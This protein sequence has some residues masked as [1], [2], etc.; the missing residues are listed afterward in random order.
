MQTRRPDRRA[1]CERKSNWWPNS[2]TTCTAIKHRVF[3][4]QMNRTGWN[5]AWG[6]CQFQVIYLASVFFCVSYYLCNL[7]AKSS[8]TFI[9]TY[10]A[11]SPVL[12][13]SPPQPPHFCTFSHSV[14]KGVKLNLRIRRDLCISIQT[15]L[16]KHYRMF[17]SAGYNI[18]NLWIPVVSWCVY[19]DR[20]QHENKCNCPHVYLISVASPGFI[21]ITNNLSFLSCYQLFAT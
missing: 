4:T 3:S 17:S 7:N 1:H 15:M 14:P 11:S 10:L 6:L 13:A 9:K 16:I 12:C 20:R 8:T 18:R 19:V 2:G 5:P 21:S